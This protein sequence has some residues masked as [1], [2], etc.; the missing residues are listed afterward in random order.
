MPGRFYRDP[1]VRDLA[2]AGFSPLLM[3]GPGLQGAGLALN[4]FW[5][6]HLAGLDRDPAPLR[7]FLG[8]TPGGRLGLYYERLWQY[9]LT[10]DPD[11]ELIAHNLPVRDGG[12]TVGEFDCLY[13]CRRRETHVHLELAVK[14]YL[15]VPGSDIWLGPGQRD[16]LDQKLER[17]ISHQSRLAMQPAGQRVLRETGI[18]NCVSVVDIKGYLFAPGGGLSPPPYHNP[19]NPLREWYRLSEFLALKALP[20]HWRGWQKIPRRRWLSSHAVQDGQERSGAELV[21]LLQSQLK[22]GGR[23]LQLAAC[24]EH[25]LEQRRC[26]VTPED[27]PSELSD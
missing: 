14:F 23:P 8:G 22:H 3:H 17:L 27:W 20:E 4:S 19:H 13:W 2:W 26:F 21:A 25:G 5:S 15:G 1:F 24:D 7:D 10:E 11:T 12:R 16:R 18:E 9:L 6:E